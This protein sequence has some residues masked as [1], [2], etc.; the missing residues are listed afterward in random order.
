MSLVI[1]CLVECHGRR[2][3]KAGEGQGIVSEIDP[4]GF[5]QGKLDHIDQDDG[6]D[7]DHFPLQA[8]AVTPGQGWLPGDGIEGQSPMHHRIKPHT[9]LP[10]SGLLVS[11][12]RCGEHTRHSYG[13]IPF[14]VSFFDIPVS[15]DNL[16]Q[17]IASIYDRF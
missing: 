1:F 12:W 17:R 9:L 6:F 7:R 14:F 10:P 4:R 5:V 2:H 11:L 3:V 15:L 16:F 13:N 8:N